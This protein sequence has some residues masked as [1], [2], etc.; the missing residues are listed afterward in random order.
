MSTSLPQTS[1]GSPRV[2]CRTLTECTTPPEECTQAS[3]SLSTLRARSRSVPCGTRKYFL[4]PG[5]LAGS[6]VATCASA[7]PSRSLWSV[8]EAKKGR[9]APGRRRVKA[10]VLVASLSPADADAVAMVDGR[11]VWD[12]CCKRMS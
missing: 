8:D 5:S 4:A 7:V 1:A 11:G 12:V 2:R 9:R 10:R 3:W 6:G